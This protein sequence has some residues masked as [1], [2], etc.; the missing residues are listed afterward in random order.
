MVGSAS[1]VYPQLTPEVSPALRLLAG[2][3][4]SLIPGVIF[5]IENYTAPIYY[6]RLVTPTRNDAQRSE[7]TPA[8]SEASDPPGL[9]L[10][11]SSSMTPAPPHRSQ[12]TI[13]FLVGIA[14]F[15]LTV[16]LVFGSIPSMTD[17]F[18]EAEDSSIVVDRIASL[19]AFEMLGDPGS[20]SALNESCTFAFFNASLGDG[21]VCPVA[22]D[23]TDPDL[24]NRVGVSSDYS[25][26]VSLRRNT[27]GD[28]T[29]DIVCTDGTAVGACPEATTL[30]TG[31]RPPAGKPV[32]T[33]RRT[34]FIDE[35][36]VELTVKLWR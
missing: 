14:L 28:A 10:I 32:F 8:G 1:A 13:D 7:K 18:A 21:A 26:N 27:T 36:D 5:Y 2:S 16:M 11:R 22:F 34:V 12:T 3:S 35:G 33:A 6:P 17:P 4:I 25:L 24:S 31:D 29:P 9:D 20:P 15:L 23:E 19:L 30:A